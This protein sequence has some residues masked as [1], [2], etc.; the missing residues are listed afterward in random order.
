MSTQDRNATSNNNPLA[1][2]GPNEWIVEDM[3]QRYLADPSSVDKTWHEFFDGYQP[4]HSAEPAVAEPATA[5]KPAPPAE[6]PE[7]PSGKPPAKPA[8]AAPA[9]PAKAASSA[10]AKAA[11]SAAPAKKADTPVAQDAAR[12]QLKGI[13]AKIAENMDVSLEIP[14][15]TSVRAIPAKLLSDNRIVINNHLRRGRGGKVSFTHLIGFALI[16]ALRTHPEMNNSYAVVDGKPTMVTPAAVNLGLAIDLK[17]D[18]GT[19]TLVVPSIKGCQ[20]MDFRQFWQAYE[21]IVRKAR[22]NKL[23]MD[24]YAGTT[25]TLTNP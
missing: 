21:D 3:Y 25:L 19:R 12:K 11:S 17:K 8:A 2:F 9:A 15:A 1:E 4:A 13:S 14:T 22:N 23:T 5:S 20:D 18:D 24:D 7:K 10:P 16:K 6:A